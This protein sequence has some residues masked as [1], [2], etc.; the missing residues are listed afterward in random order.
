MHI[1]TLLR[2]SKQPSSKP[3]NPRPEISAPLTDAEYQLYCERRQA[4]ASF[5]ERKGHLR[6][7]DLALFLFLANREV[8][9]H[10]PRVTAD[11]LEKL[12]VV[13]GEGEEV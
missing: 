5:Y 9:W 12:C 1:P 8:P 6:H 4:V 11:G 10:R 7:T 13:V 3:A 2:L